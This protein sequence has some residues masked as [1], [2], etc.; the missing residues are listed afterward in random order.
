MT[1]M[2]YKKAFF[3]PTFLTRAGSLSGLDA[4]VISNG[5]KLPLMLPEYSSNK[6]FQNIIRA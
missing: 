4:A 1:S 2:N 6:N 3:R 5:F